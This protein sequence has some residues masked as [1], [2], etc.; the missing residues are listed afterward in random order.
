[1]L[2]KNKKNKEN[3]QPKQE[4]KL[5]IN[6]DRVKPAG[7]KQGKTVKVVGGLVGLIVVS[8][9][10][11]TAINSQSDK[12]VEVIK[13]ISSVPQG[14]IL[15]E[16]N[17]K[18]E[19]MMNK[20]YLRSG[21]D[22]VGKG[23]NKTE[24]R[25]ILL[26]SEK[27]TIVGK[28]A[29]Y[30][31]RRDTPLHWDAIGEE[32]SRKNSYL[33]SMDGELL[34]I[35]LAPGDFGGMIVPG[36]RINV[37]IIYNEEVYKLPTKEEI[38]LQERTGIEPKTTVEKQEK[39]FNNVPVLDMLNSKQ[40]SIFDIY[41]ELMTLPKD[42]QEK[43]LAEDGFKEKVTPTVILLN[44]TPEEADH[45]MAI[46]NKGPQYLLTLLP[47]TNSNAITELINE[48]NTGLAKNEKKVNK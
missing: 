25:S 21:V 20:E 24:R 6:R 40:E 22:V 41:Y 14:G 47:R 48:I 36:D 27:D 26:A 28:T 38:V 43:R 23:E 4:Q 29:A 42:E 19:K 35:D 3:A 34:K 46:K 44:A 15:Q 32:V 18:Y 33:Y 13:L 16:S 37:R 2:F 30:F 12:E 10:A 39:L 17:F 45:Y 5:T 11:M 31:I 1:M 8:L 9:G 7:R